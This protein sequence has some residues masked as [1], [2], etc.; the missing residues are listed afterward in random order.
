[1]NFPY[2]SGVGIYNSELFGYKKSDLSPQRVVKEYEIELFEEDYTYGILDGN[3]IPYK[4]GTV[5]V[6]K[7]GNRRCSRMNFSCY[8]LHISVKDSDLIQELEALPSQFYISGM[9]EYIAIFTHMAALFPEGLEESSLEMTGLFFLLLSNLRRDASMLGMGTQAPNL[10]KD[11]IQKVR[12]LINENYDKDLSL[13]ALAEC[14]HFHPNHLHR[15]FTSVCHQTP[16]AYLTDVRLHHAKYYLL[17][18]SYNITE[19]AKLCGFSTYN[20]FCTVF[21]KKVGIPPREFRK[22]TNNYYFGMS[23]TEE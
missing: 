19:I 6:A 15:V 4:K 8:Y 5:L 2:V 18:T 17:N 14:V 9:E 3:Q 11:A 23:S 1:M 16:L 10:Q 7:P 12:T 20:Y 13:A 21:K 22:Q